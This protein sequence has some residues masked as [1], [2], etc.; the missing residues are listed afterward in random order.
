MHIQGYVYTH[1]IYVYTYIHTYI[2]IYNHIHVHCTCSSVAQ[3][4]KALIFNPDDRL[5]PSSLWTNFPM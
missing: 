5:I 2:P 1:H 4:V 3:S